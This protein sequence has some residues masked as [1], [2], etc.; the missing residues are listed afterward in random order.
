[1]K[2]E[3]KQNN[4]SHSELRQDI[5]TGDWVVI[6]TGRAKRPEDFSKNEKAKE[7]RG[8]SDIEDCLFCD[9]EKSGQEKD[10]LI[11]E[12]PDGDWS[13]RVFPNKYPAFSHN[14][15][16]NKL[17]EG[18]Y[19]SMN[20]FGYHEV[21]LTRDHYRHIALLEELEIAE[22]FDAYQDRYLDLMN[23]SGINYISVFHNYGKEVGASIAH[24][25]SQLMAVPVVSPYVEL[26]LRGAELYRKINNECVYCLM[27]EYESEHKQRVVFENDE[28][29]AFCPFASRAA[30]E[31][32]VMPKKHRPYFERITKKEKLKVAE[33]F[34]KATHSIY[35]A[36]NDPPYN[37]YIHTS[38]CDGKDYP[39]YHWHIEILPHTATWAGF[40][41]Q[42]GIEISTIQ[43]EIAAEYLRKMM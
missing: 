37:F 8:D 17:G 7:A 12:K 35:R 19:F 34:K 43:P 30:F 29:I 22:V 42:T 9:P 3:I 33:V 25:H 20:G 39:H 10:V 4:N 40:E 28:F 38:P 18:P 1:M 21:I 14:E 15:K 36:L 11:Y 27:A 2:T 41:L 6:A 31:V 13:L 26:E 23:K 24:P 16:I 5:V 32:W